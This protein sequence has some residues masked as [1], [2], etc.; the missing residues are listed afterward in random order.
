M[1]GEY[2]RRDPSDVS[3]EDATGDAVEQPDADEMGG[4][5]EEVPAADSLVEQ[6]REIGEGTGLFEMP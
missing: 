4:E 5:V 3:R 1:D 2:E 6:E